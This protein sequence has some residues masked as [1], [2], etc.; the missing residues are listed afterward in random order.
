MHKL[1]VLTVSFDE[2][3]QPAGIP[4]FRG[5]I[6][7]KVGQEATLFHQHKKDLLRYCYPLIQYKSL[8]GKPTMVCLQEGVENI[9]TLFSQPDAAIHLGTQKVELEIHDIQLNEY[10]LQVGQR[11]FTYHIPNWIGLNQQNWRS[12]QQLN[13]HPGR[14][15]FLRSILLG[16]ILSFAKGIGWQINDRVKVD[17]DHLGEPYVVRMKGVKLRAFP[18]TFHTNVYLPSQIGLGGKVSHGFGVLNRMEKSKTY[19]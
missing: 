2:N 13:D 7:R 9:Q 12:Y 18:I 4:A 15:K 3:I 17:I 6:S 8:A 16:N 5:A 19:S 10:H 11:V 14:L 1:N